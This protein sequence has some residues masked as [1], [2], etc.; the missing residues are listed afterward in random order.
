MHSLKG[1]KFDFK[2]A[3][4]RIYALLST[5][6]IT[7][8]ARFEPAVFR[9]PRSDIRS[10]F[11]N[12]VHGS[13]MTEVFLTMHLPSSTILNV[14]YSPSS[15]YTAHVMAEQ[16]VETNE[17]WL[18]IHSTPRAD[19][20]TVVHM[21]IVK[22][23]PIKDLRYA[24]KVTD[25]AWNI[26]ITTGSCRTISDKL[27]PFVNV[28]IS[29]MPA[30]FANPVAAHGLIGQ[31]LHDPF[32]IQ[33][34]IDQYVPNAAGEVVTSAQGEGAIEGTMEDYEI[35]G[36]PFSGNFKFSRFGAKTGSPRNMALLSGK[37]MPI[38]KPYEAVALGDRLQGD[39]P[40]PL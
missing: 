5:P 1:G 10:T 36:G 33:G 38:G 29:P 39:E 16:E 17:F 4:K 31:S 35:V 22:T 30:A 32:A 20:E 21:A 14:N 25:C 18:D 13:F 6:N 12:K 34:K 8:S 19:F 26:S 15:P 2:G 28:E 37:K 27:L 9:L 24:L 23:S 40:S 11:V 3:A 7:L